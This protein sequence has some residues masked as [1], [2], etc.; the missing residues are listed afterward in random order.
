MSEEQKEQL[1]PHR[2]RAE[3][4][5]R[6]QLSLISGVPQTLIFLFHK[7]DSHV[8]TARECSLYM[9]DQIIDQYANLN[10]DLV[11]SNYIGEKL[12]FWGRVRKNI[13]TL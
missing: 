9:V 10:R 7:G 12:I 3:R 11:D 8:E 4:I 2:E 6:K 1:R 5:L 13:E